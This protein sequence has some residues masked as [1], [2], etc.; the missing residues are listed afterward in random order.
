VAQERS[1]LCSQHVS[2][3]RPAPAEA[4]MISCH[5]FKPPGAG[6][7][8]LGSVL[9]SVLVSVSTCM[10]QALT[11]S[12][13]HMH[14]CK[15]PCITQQLLTS[16]TEQVDLR[17]IHIT[18]HVPELVPVTMQLHQPPHPPLHPPPAPPCPPSPPPPSPPAW[19]PAREPTWQQTT[20]P[21]CCT[22]IRGALAPPRQSS[23][24]SSTPATLVQPSSLEALSSCDPIRQAC[25]AAWQCCQRPQPS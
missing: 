20:P 17:Y 5:V 10:L 19:P 25:C 24:H 8:V 1:Q 7:V 6:C 3:S 4:S 13:N 21:A 14:V 23:S 2:C 9:L 12:T 11:Y 15:L 18:N 22:P 16:C